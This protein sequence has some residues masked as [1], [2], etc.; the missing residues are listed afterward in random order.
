MEF[1][2]SSFEVASSLCD[3]DRTLDDCFVS[4]AVSLLD[5]SASLISVN[6]NERVEMLRLIFELLNP[7]FFDVGRVAFFS[8]GLFPSVNSEMM[9]ES[10]L[11]SPLMFPS[12]TG[13]G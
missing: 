10:S 2:G 9:V 6:D 5:S 1:D 4:S 12:M 3:S 13:A 11:G 8:P 7:V